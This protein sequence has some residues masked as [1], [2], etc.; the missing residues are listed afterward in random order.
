MLQDRCEPTACAHDPSRSALEDLLIKSQGSLEP[1]ALVAAREARS[2]V[3]KS[4]ELARH[5]RSTEHKKK[6]KREPNPCRVP[7]W[8]E[9]TNLLQ[10]QVSINELHVGIAGSI[11]LQHMAETLP[12][13]AK[14]ILILYLDPLIPNHVVEPWVLSQLSLNDQPPQEGC[15]KP[16]LRLHRVNEKEETRREKGMSWK[17]PARGQPWAHDLNKL[18]VTVLQQ[19]AASL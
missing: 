18:I 14:E 13:N 19:K 9:R 8:A 4:L 15:H 12:E 7:P 5:M 11:I 6:K 10:S 1:T 17:H 3:T 2:F 16:F